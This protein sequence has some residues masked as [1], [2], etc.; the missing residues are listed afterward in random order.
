MSSATAAVA[1]LAA[2]SRRP[3]DD[4]IDVSGLTHLG[5]VRQSNQDH[6]LL[7]G[8]NGRRTIPLACDDVPGKNAGLEPANATRRYTN[9]GALVSSGAWLG[10]SDFRH[11]HS[12]P[13]FPCHT[14]H[15]SAVATLTHPMYGT[16][17]QPADRRTRANC[18]IVQ[19]IITHRITIS[20]RARAPRR[21]AKKIQV[22]SA[23]STS[24]ATNSGVPASSRPFHPPH[25]VARAR[26]A[27]RRSP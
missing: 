10:R 18:H 27:R 9:P 4:E 8:L 17:H 16:R 26:R 2:T 5:T 20:A 24:W 15:V 7:W 21:H 12:R 6:F 13:G 25:R 19:K 23:L 11:D 22:Q 14:A 3:C 1:D